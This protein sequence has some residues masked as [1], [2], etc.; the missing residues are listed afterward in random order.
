MD[1]F[2]DESDGFSIQI[3]PQMFN[4]PWEYENFYGVRNFVT[5]VPGARPYIA[6][7]NNMDPYAKKDIKEFLCVWKRLINL[8]D[9][10]SLEINKLDKDPTPDVE[11]S[12]DQAHIVSTYESN[13]AFFKRKY[14]FHARSDLIKLTLSKID[15]INYITMVDFIM[16]IMK[17]GIFIP[18]NSLPNVIC[19][20]DDM[21]QSRLKMEIVTNI[22][23]TVDVFKGYLNIIDTTTSRMFGNLKY[24]IRFADNYEVNDYDGAKDI[25]FNTEYI[26]K[27]E[28]DAEFIMVVNRE[29]FECLEELLADKFNVIMIIGEYD[30]TTRSF[31]HKLSTDFL[32]PVFILTD[33]SPADLQMYN[34][35]RFGSL[36]TIHEY[37]NVNNP[38]AQSIG[39]N[40]SDL[41]EFPFIASLA[42]P[43][44]LA[45]YD[46]LESLRSLRSIINPNEMN[47]EFNYLQHHNKVVTIKSI[48]ENYGH[49]LMESYL[50]SKIKAAFDCEL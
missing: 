13:E 28:T 2:H 47:D 48:L 41:K 46:I 34:I 3:V 6:K 29:V 36:S 18:M 4:D 30:I 1:E 40:S 15:C 16:D 42:K 10:L 20:H 12:F 27:M 7:V 45:D 8:R 24:S 50:P 49:F 44:E 31:V 5:Q 22:C 9:G 25:P 26:Y 43:F 19:P 35:Y 39:I 32:I 23:A 38:S 11:A 14:G 37:M 33:S 17:K 21:S